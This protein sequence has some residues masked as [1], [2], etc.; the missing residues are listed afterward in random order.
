MAQPSC[1]AEPGSTG[2]AGT[3]VGGA[4]PTGT[5]RLSGLSVHSRRDGDRT[6]V[7]VSG[8]FDLALDLAVDQQ[9]Q[10]ALQLASWCSEHADEGVGGPELGGVG[11]CDCSTVHI[12]LTI[13]EP[14][15]SVPG[16]AA[17]GAAGPDGAAAPMDHTG[18]TDKKD[19]ADHADHTRHAGQADHADPGADAGLELGQLR[20]AMESRGTID[21]ARG[22]LM[23]AFGVS[24]EDAWSALVMTSQN[25]NTK[26]R[27]V[28]QQVVD[29]AGGAPLPQP[30]QRQLSAAM[31][32]L[33]TADSAPGAA[34]STGPA[35][36]GLAGSEAP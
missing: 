18:P 28:A 30:V 27:R 1:T 34:Q 8:E 11:R 23:A 6:V 26:L 14:S 9:L 36:A 24:P 33:S 32:K 22:I 2:S 13:G 10:H 3:C 31:A 16:T 25:T 21:L 4:R 7:S 17:L 29:S 12:W 5:R 15:P 35:D 19:H 20:R